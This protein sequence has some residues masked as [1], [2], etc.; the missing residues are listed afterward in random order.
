MQGGG[1]EKK[2]RGGM[3]ERVKRDEMRGGGV[4]KKI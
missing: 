4:A 2:L 3:P 1:V